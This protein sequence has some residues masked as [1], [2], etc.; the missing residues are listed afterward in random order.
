MTQLEI[1][2]EMLA[3][4]EAMTQ[5]INERTR[6]EKAMCNEWLAILESQ[7]AEYANIL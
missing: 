2:N 1:I 5:T 7:N 4:I 3:D 6:R